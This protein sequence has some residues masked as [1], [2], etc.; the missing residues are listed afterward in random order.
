MKR[1]WGVV[2]IAPAQSWPF[3]SFTSCLSNDCRG[4]RLAAVVLLATALITVGVR[5]LNE[6]QSRAS[7][8]RSSSEPITM[9]C[10]ACDLTMCVPA[11]HA[12]KM[13]RCKECREEF[14]VDDV[15]EEVMPDDRPAPQKESRRFADGVDYRYRALRC[16]SSLACS[17]FPCRAAAGASRPRNGK[18]VPKGSRLI[19][20]TR[21]KPTF[22]RLALPRTR[23]RSCRKVPGDC[24]FPLRAMLIT[25]GPRGITNSH[26]SF[27]GRPRKPARFT[28]WSRGLSMASVI[29]RSTALE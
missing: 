1:T 21:V 26:I 16:W 18:R 12:G 11:K 3:C 24:A 13:I 23:G 2:F 7:A 9:T 6:P 20:R 15:L 17:S 8:R 25:L 10:P 4:S 5:W 14:R 29:F 28:I 19:P 22:R 27:R